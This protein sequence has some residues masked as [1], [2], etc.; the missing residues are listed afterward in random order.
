MSGVM[1]PFDTLLGVVRMRASSS[2]TL[3]FPSLLAT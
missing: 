2:R 3:M 1:N